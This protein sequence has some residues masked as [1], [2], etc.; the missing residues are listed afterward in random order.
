MRR[1][2]P[3]FGILAIASLALVWFATLGPFGVKD[4]IHDALD[5]IAAGFDQI[6]GLAWVSFGM[7]EFAA[8]V[9]LFLPIGFCALLFFGVQRWWLAALAGVLLSV[10]VELA[11]L[12]LPGTPSLRDVLSNSLG[13][14]GG[15][16]L[17]WAFEKLR[18]RRRHRDS[19]G[20][21]ATGVAAADG[22]S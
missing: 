20:D 5:V 2:R 13:T 22:S 9:V 15:V 17:A 8:N 1:T 11:Q 4:A 21:A 18:L 10:F 16:A 12:V 19:V 14:L 7:L 3:L 6:P